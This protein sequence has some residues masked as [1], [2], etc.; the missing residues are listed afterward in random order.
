MNELL[1]YYLFIIYIEVIQNKTE[2]N[3]VLIL[4]KRHTK[5]QAEYQTP[6][7]ILIIRDKA[8]AK[9]VNFSFKG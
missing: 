9:V 5:I 3:C 8:Y 1:N 6:K 4:S 7:K 2:I